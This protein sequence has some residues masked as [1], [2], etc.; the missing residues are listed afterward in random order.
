MPNY[1]AVNDVWSSADGVHWSRETAAAGWSPRLWFSAVVYRNAI[2]VLGGWS[3]N[4][5][6]NWG[7]VWYSKDG[8]QWTQFKSRVVWKERHE[9]S[10]YVFQDKIWVAG[11][12]AKPLNSEVWS[13]QLP[14]NWTPAP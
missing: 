9:H 6:K 2:W 11:G 13:L 5:S 1:Q 10:S 4:P 12:H 14:K 7:D 8:R 3:N